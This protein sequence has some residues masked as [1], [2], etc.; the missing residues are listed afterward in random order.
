MRYEPIVK[1]TWPLLFTVSHFVKLRN[2][3]DARLADTTY[4]HR[5]S[6]Q[7]AHEV[8]LFG[9]VAASHHWNISIDTET[10]DWHGDNGIDLVIDGKKVSVKTT[11]YWDE[12]LLRVEIEHFHKD[13]FYFCAAADMLRKLVKFVGWA[14]PDEVGKGEKRIFVPGG[15]ENFVLE[16]EVLH[17]FERKQ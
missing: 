6:P 8:G 17:E 9:E 5:Q 1:M 2:A 14:S 3:K 11:T 10:Y 12:P 4:G 7:S 16:R 13:S 15:P